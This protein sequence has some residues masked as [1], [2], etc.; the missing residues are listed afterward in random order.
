MAYLQMPSRRYLEGLSKST[1]N[2]RQDRRT[3][4]L[5][6]GLPCYEAGVLATG[7]RLSFVTGVVYRIDNPRNLAYV[8]CS[9]TPHPILFG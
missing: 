9:C 5:D 4:A 8:S 2:I 3:L 7:P 6:P 1:K